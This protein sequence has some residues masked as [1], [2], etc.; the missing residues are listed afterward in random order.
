MKSLDGVNQTLA[1]LGQAAGDAHTVGQTEGC[2]VAHD[3]AMRQKRAS[4]AGAI[5][6][7]H[8]DKVRQRWLNLEAEV[9]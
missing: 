1:L 2:A 9:R 4:E 6:D 8:Q 3:D 5:A 7:T